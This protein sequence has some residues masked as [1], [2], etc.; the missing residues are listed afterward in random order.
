MLMVLASEVKNLPRFE[1]DQLPSAAKQKARRA[2][3]TEE[4]NSLRRDIED[5]K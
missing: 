2:C 3:L 5:T 4:Q 1:Y